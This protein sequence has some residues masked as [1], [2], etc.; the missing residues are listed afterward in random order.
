M[1]MMSTALSSPL[2]RSLIPEGK[3]F[4]DDAGRGG[5]SDDETVTEDDSS[6]LAGRFRERCHL[7]HT[8]FFRLYKGPL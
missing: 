4:L 5:D 6:L 1:K 8:I 3:I 2:W 7:D